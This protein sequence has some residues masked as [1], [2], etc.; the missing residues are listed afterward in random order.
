M[1]TWN[2]ES[3]GSFRTAFADADVDRTGI[4]LYDLL[5]NAMPGDGLQVL[6][7]VEGFSAWKVPSAWE[8]FRSFSPQTCAEKLG[9]G[10]PALWVGAEAHPCS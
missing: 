10:C 6:R 1:P 5:A 4:E 7:A 3:L 8:A 9:V 2:F